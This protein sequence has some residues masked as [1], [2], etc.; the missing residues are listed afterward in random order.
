MCTMPD[1]RYGFLRASNRLLCAARF[2][3]GV[4]ALSVQAVV[5]EHIEDILAEHKINWHRRQT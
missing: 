3:P 4:Y 1:K 5:P 2:V